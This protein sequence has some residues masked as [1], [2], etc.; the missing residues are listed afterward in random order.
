MTENTRAA[1]GAVTLNLPAMGDNARQGV[2]A[3]R[4]NLQLRY[5]QAR[6]IGIASAGETARR[7]LLSLRLA[8]GIA[9]LG[10]ETVCVDCD[11]GCGALAGYCAGVS[12][13]AGLTEYLSGEATDVVFPTATP[14][15]SVVCA[16]RPAED[17][18]ALLSGRD[19]AA[20]I[21]TL[22]DRYDCVVADIPAIN[23]GIDGALAARVCDG[24][25]LL[26]EAGVTKSDQVRRTKA[27]LE[28][29]GIPLL[30]CALMA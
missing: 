3:L 9:A 24:V 25:V 14:H 23:A 12:P 4:G 11:P 13:A 26:I 20:F 19:Y 17:A 2:H 8:A 18:G 28:A 7:S 21:G 6:V 10:R 15:L 30:G 16:G 1:N 5:P 27:L 29:A 22:R